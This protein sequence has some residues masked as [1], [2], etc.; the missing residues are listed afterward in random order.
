VRG[1]W[2]AA[3][4]Q[5]ADQISSTL[6]RYA[7]QIKVV[8]VAN[9][10]VVCTTS[11]KNSASSDIICM[12]SAS[13]CRQLKHKP[14][15]NQEE[16]FGEVTDPLGEETQEVTDCLRQVV[17]AEN[18]YH[19]DDAQPPVPEPVAVQP[20]PSAEEHPPALL[21][22]HRD[23]PESYPRPDDQAFQ[24]NH[25]RTSVRMCPLAKKLLNDDDDLERKSTG[26]TPTAYDY[27]SDE[28]PLSEPAPYQ[29]PK[30][31]TPEYETDTHSTD[32]EE[33]C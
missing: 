17:L 25:Y 2:P 13:Q 30:Y 24:T 18:P 8:G 6:N 19:E 31:E 21:G 15:T 33:D 16:D 9:N 28:C 11:A 1:A 26:E 27:S 14:P 10:E 5:Y 29:S 7:A 32:T 3:I 23:I 4:S 20:R 12:S 22:T